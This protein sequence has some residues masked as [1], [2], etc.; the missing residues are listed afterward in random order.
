MKLKVKKL[1]PDAHIPSRAKP[2][3]SGLD[4]RLY[5]AR[6]GAAREIG[7]LPGETV[8]VRTGIAIELPQAELVYAGGG[9]WDFSNVVGFEAQVRGRSGLT[10]KGIIACGGIGT[11]DNGY[12]GEIGVTLYNSSPGV[13]FFNHG[14][15]I[16]QLV[17]VP[18][19]YPDVEEVTEL[20][21]T[22]RGTGGFGSTG[23]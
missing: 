15:R 2:G 6:T 17:V 18:V 8:R 19:V 4:L 14:D 7:I 11:V 5:V 1:E 12:R 21:E 3:D 23:V 22:E 16:A 10:S 9:I 20:S 13:V